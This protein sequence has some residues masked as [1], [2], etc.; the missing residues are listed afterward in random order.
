MVAQ[1][2]PFTVRLRHVDRGLLV[3]LAVFV[4]CLPLWTGRFYAVDSVEYF[5]Y[6][7]AVLLHHTLDF[8]EEYTYFD[9]HNPHAGIAK[10]LLVPEKRDPVTGRPINVAPI[11]TAVLWSPAFLLTHVV[12]KI[13]GGL[14]FH[15]RADGLSVPYTEAVAIAST[16]YGLAGLLV[17]YLIVRRWTGVWAATWAVIACALASPV[18]FYTYVS[19]PWSHGPGLCITALFIWYWLRTRPAPTV[20]QWVMLAVLG[21]L[22]AL[23]REQLGLWLLLP[24]LDAVVAYGHALRTHDRSQLWQLVRQHA[25]FSLV[26]ALVLVPQFLSYH[27]LTGAYHP[28]NHVAGKLQAGW[29]SPH[30]LDTLIDPQHGAFLWTPV[31]LLGVLGLGWFWRRDRRMTIMMLVA[32]LAQVYINGSL[33]PTWHLAGSFGFRRLIE[34]TP[35]FA[36]GLACLIEGLRPPRPLVGLVCALLVAWN[37]GLI[38]QWSLPPRPIQKGLVWQGML[39]RQAEVPVQV[40]G[41]FNDL[42]F[43]RCRLVQNGNC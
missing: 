16:L 23:C 17:S 8:T 20:R 27:A 13:M 11:G 4:L 29:W 39:S 26:L 30:F 21:G 6:L 28:S 9:Q 37:L 18:V 3:L 24:A 1:R 36:L 5:A 41:K 7:P 19:P 34:A 14:G 25:L 40:A 43:H 15:V 42:L 35:V 22:M 2:Q 12:L 10:G 32:L 38:V 31:W 33:G